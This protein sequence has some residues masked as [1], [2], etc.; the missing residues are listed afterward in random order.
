MPRPLP[1]TAEATAAGINKHRFPRATEIKE[2]E[3]KAMAVAN[4]QCLDTSKAVILEEV[5]AEVSKV[6]ETRVEGSKVAGTK[7]VEIKVAAVVNNHHPT[8]LKEC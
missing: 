2:V 8:A 1:I 7:A 6:A 3:T 4:I 5:E